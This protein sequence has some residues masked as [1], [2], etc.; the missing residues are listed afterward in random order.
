MHKYLRRMVI[1]NSDLYSGITIDKDG[2]LHGATKTDS[3]GVLIVHGTSIL[4]DKHYP[5]W[6]QTLH[7][8]WQYLEESFGEYLRGY[9]N[10]IFNEY[11][12]TAEWYFHGPL[13]LAAE[14]Q[15]KGAQH[16]VNRFR[17]FVA[18]E[19]VSIYVDEHYN[20]QS[21]RPM[22]QWSDDEYEQAYVVYVHSYYAKN[23]R[24]PE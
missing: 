14:E 3:S 22:K 2:I 20:D 8:F 11:L 17:L 5:E 19:M 23:K 6:P 16:W 18:Y 1:G 10:R 15:L 24:L 13:R 9:C 12:T 21:Y 4:L 7:G